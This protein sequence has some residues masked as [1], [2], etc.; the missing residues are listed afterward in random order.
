MKILVSDIFM[1]CFVLPV[2]YALLQPSLI[3]LFVKMG[4]DGHD[5]MRTKSTL[6]LLFLTRC[7]STKYLRG[8]IKL[9]ENFWVADKSKT[10]TRFDHLGK[11][12]VMM[13][14]MVVVLTLMVMIVVVVTLMVIYIL[15]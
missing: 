13:L 3:S 6:D 10:C 12:L 7:S 2:Q 14:L 11:I 8:E 1:A 4:S 9:G 5:S 15:C